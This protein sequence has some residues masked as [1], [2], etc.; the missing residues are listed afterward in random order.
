MTSLNAEKY[1]RGLPL[2]NDREMSERYA[3]LSA[4][5]TGMAETSRRVFHI[6]CDG[7]FSAHTAAM[8]AAAL[9]SAG[10]SSASVAFDALCEDDMRHTIVFVDG[11][12]AP[13]QVFSPAVREL[14]AAMRAHGNISGRYEAGAALAVLSCRNS[15]ARV[16]ISDVSGLP[17]EVLSLLPPPSCV[18]LGPVDDT[19]RPAL[20]RMISKSTFE[21]VSTP[22]SPE[23]QRML[24]DTCAAAGCRLTVAA[25]H[26]MPG[27][28]EVGTLTF[29]GVAFSYRGVD[30]RISSVFVS[31]V[32]CACAAT[33]TVR[34]MRRSGFAIS[35]SDIAAGVR[36][37]SPLCHGTVVSINPA[38]IVAS[39][40]DDGGH[41]ERSTALA[42]VVADIA[43]AKQLTGK[44][45][46][47]FFPGSGAPADEIVSAFG[48]CG[49]EVSAVIL[50][51]EGESPAAAARRAA[52]EIVIT[53]AE[54]DAQGDTDEVRSYII[55]GTRRENEE[56]LPL[57][58]E[59][60][61]RTMI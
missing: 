4:E 9:R 26:G 41:A 24:T 5:M 28:P 30:A 21:T 14:R 15:G 44:S 13:E 43:S 57:L 48:G 39:V 51:A 35:D 61:R 2:K 6:C 11:K 46:T 18:V 37:S 20:R 1:L 19:I 32:L 7:L 50:A 25:K 34:A 12:R 16:L 56:A 49:V 54:I 22:Q 60:I 31:A 10:V 47:L 23:I 52:S 58:R 55:I 38:V 42:A 29:G 27:G 40:P 17:C 3:A 53:D 45:V 8:L 59:G 36:V 33:D